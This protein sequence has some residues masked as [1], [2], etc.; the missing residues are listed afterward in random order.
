MTVRPGKNLLWLAASLLAVALAT[1]VWSGAAW[2]LPLLVVAG[3]AL[4]VR[5]YR[6]L[7]QSFQAVSVRRELPP[8]VGR[9]LPFEVA[10]HF[11]SQAP[12]AL[13]GTLRDI[14]S[15]RAE[16]NVWIRPLQLAPRGTAELRQPFRIATRGLYAFG[17]VWVRLRGPA[18]VLEGQQALACGG[19][20]QV[21]PEGLVSKEQLSRDAAQELRLL[22]KQMHTRQRG[23]GTEFESLSEFRA[24]DDPRRIDWRTT[25]R[26]R[27][28][29][30]RRYQVERCRDLVILL[31]CGRL[32]GADAQKG[33]KLDC[34]VDAALMLARVAL[35]G[36][37]RCGLG[38]F[39]D[40]VLGYLPPVG[41]HPAMRTLTQTVYNLQSAWRETDFGPM[42]SL[43]QS[44]QT[45]RSLVVI[46]SDIAD[47]ETTD[48]YRLSLATL[49][50]RH[51]M[52]FA[53][54]QTPLLKSVVHAP[55]AELLD[56]YRKAVSLRILREREGALHGL[57]RSDVHVLDVVPSQL[58]LPLVNQYLGLRRQN[59]L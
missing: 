9:D 40:R 26:Y 45:K 52:L 38:V 31:D 55:M 6:R 25:A 41:G 36:G 58:T 8:I 13:Q 46:L 56:G 28:P 33:T 27:R 34:A 50:K 17:P 21:L 14:V 39:D 32:M 44:R 47:A 24:G 49:A 42:F 4:A 37:D 30:V 11:T 43:L 23:T 10:L 48:R 20:V 5:D 51:I 7:R 2:L 18:G 54:L 19:S 16:P 15:P 3:A 1:A 12:D 57:R 53:A 59:L 29:I 35:S 22:E